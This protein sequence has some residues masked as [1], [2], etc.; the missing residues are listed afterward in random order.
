MIRSSGGEAVL[1]PAIEIVDPSDLTSLN[2][3]IDLL[4]TFDLAIFISPAAVKR[5]VKQVR[6][7]REWP[8]RLPLAAVGPGSARALEACGFQNIV[9]PAGQSDSEALLAL[10][11]LNQVSGKRMVIFR[12]EGGREMLAE[13]LRQRGAEVA[14]AECYRRAKPQASLAPILDAHQQTPLSAITITSAE[15]LDNLFDIAGA[16]NQPV[17]ARI[18]FFVPHRRIAESAR[19]R[20]IRTIIMTAGGDAG[21]VEGMVKF[22]P[23]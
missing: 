1:F 12:G 8:A 17:L 4:H 9:A 5:G 18:P 6:T 11:E 21:L 23:S 3:Q 16:A 2:K 10:P 7:R 15:A 14:Y 19:Q 13:T 20:G 22:F